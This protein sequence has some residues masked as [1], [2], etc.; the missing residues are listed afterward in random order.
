MSLRRREYSDPKILKAIAQG[1]VNWKPEIL[2]HVCDQIRPA[3]R[4]R[5]SNIEDT[6]IMNVFADMKKGEVQSQGANRTT[7]ES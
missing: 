5:F 3:V 1:I 4:E 2:Q 6:R 7:Q